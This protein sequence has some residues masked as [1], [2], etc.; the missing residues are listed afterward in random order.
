V[1]GIRRKAEKSRK[2]GDVYRSFAELQAA[3]TEGVDYA[4]RVDRRPS[5]V[6]VLAIHAGGIEPGTGALAAAIA[7]AE[8]T[9]Y[10][11]EGLKPVGNARLHLT[12][13]RF[14][15][16]RCLAVLAAAHIALSVHGCRGRRPAVHVGGRHRTLRSVM[17]SA[18]DAA[19][20]ELAVGATDGKA[21][22]APGNICNR[23]KSGM[24]IQ[25]E[26]AEGL[27]RRFFDPLP[28]RNEGVRTTFF[29]RFVDAVRT[30]LESV[31]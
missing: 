12:S 14:D 18:I 4:V 19:G 17:A 31:R 13:T 1:T 16:P 28:R 10:L 29:D 15:E 25:L 7:G 3:E 30:V 6:A 20:L 22:R 26:V 24:G 2:T 5:A 21:G 11:F 23:C 9:L 8:H 27:R